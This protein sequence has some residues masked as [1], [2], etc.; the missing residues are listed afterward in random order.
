MRF[1]RTF[2]LRLDLFLPAFLLLL[3][4]LG[5]ASAG[6]VKSTAA[7]QLSLSVTVYNQDL[8]LVKEVRNL[9]LP[10]GT[11]ELDFEGV[12][13]KIDPTSVHIRSLSAPEKL[14]VLEQNF[15]YDLINPAKL[16]EKYLGREVELVAGEKGKGTAKVRRAKLIGLEGGYVYE[17]D[18][19]IEINPPGRVVLPSLPEGLI[20][21]PSLIWLL[22]N[23]KK[24]QKVEVSYLTSGMSWHANYVA[25]LAQDEKEAALSGW[26]TLDNKSGATYKNARLKL[27]AGKV[28]RVEKVMARPLMARATMAEKA[29]GGRFEE[30]GLFEYHIYQLDEKTTLKNNQTKQI[31]LMEAPGVKVEKSF[32]CLP[33]PAFLSRYPQQKAKLAVGVYLSFINSR[34]SGLG[35]PLPEGVVRLYKKDRDGSLE[36]IGEDRISHTPEEE[37]VRLQIGQAF[38]IVAERVQEDFRE[39]KRTYESTYLITVRNHKEQDVTVSVVERIPGD[40]KIKQ[41]THEFVKESA[42]RVRFDLP[43]PAKGKTDL[44]YTV[45][46]KR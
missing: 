21:R 30:R 19:K 2:A 18:G 39:T 40:W 34:R 14:R 20:S 28:H 26:V 10:P 9:R 32:V 8:G 35:L 42:H 43:V 44:R 1:Y 4:P 7:D 45:S 3:F 17:I 13:A 33:Q 36:F 5:A 23:E 22:E 46:I 31:R 12:A 25:V 6:R 41:K 38:D 11:L 16:M 29:G 24:N 27:V 37:K 15:E